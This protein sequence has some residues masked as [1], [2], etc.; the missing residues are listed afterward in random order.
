MSRLILEK[1]LHLIRE[2]LEA[3][4][5][6][7]GEEMTADDKRA[8]GEAMRE[9]KEGKTVA[10]RSSGS[11]A[12]KRWRS[13]YHAR[14][15]KR[16][17][18]RHLKS[19]SDSKRGCLNSRKRLILR[20]FCGEVFL[21]RDRSSHYYAIYVIWNGF[22][23]GNKFV[24]SRIKT[25]TALTF[26]FEMPQILWHSSSLV[27]PRRPNPESS[28]H[29]WVPFSIAH[30]PPWTLPS[31]SCIFWDSPSLVS[32]RYHRR[33]EWWCVSTFN[34]LSIKWLSIHKKNV[35]SSYVS[36]F[37]GVSNTGSLSPRAENLMVWPQTPNQNQRKNKTIRKQTH[38]AQ[39]AR[40]LLQYGYR[41]GGPGGIRT[42]D[43]EGSRPKLHFTTSEFQSYEASY[44]LRESRGVDGMRTHH[45][46]WPIVS[47]A[48][49]SITSG[50][51]IHTSQRDVTANHLLGLLV[52]GIFFWK[53]CESILCFLLTE[54]GMSN[55]QR[56]QHYD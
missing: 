20:I 3:I 18:R 24:V 37:S 17:K 50:F 27:F 28:L 33:A 43:I 40:I 4:E 5:D 26:L 31:W 6:A 25:Q 23:H 47:S 12:R 34:H 39:R 30:L 13:S 14:R 29:L 46:G 36:L 7:L 1:E 2:R 51:K 22:P 49:R 48:G 9:H 55:E 32:C 41:A 8:L 42:L 16:L 52:S 53:S 56:D 15:R 21:I 19:D 45:Y 38:C 11:R 10:F 54:H 44:S 35:W